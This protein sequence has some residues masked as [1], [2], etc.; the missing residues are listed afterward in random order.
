MNAARYGPLCPL[1]L[2]SGA[3]LERASAAL[4]TEAQ[5]AESWSEGFDKEANSCR[6]LRGCQQLLWGGR[7]APARCGAC[8]D[9]F[10]SPTELLGALWQAHCV[11][12]EFGP[13]QPCPESMPS[14]QQ[15][16][17]LVSSRE[18]GCRALSANLCLQA[19]P[20]TFPCCPTANSLAPPCRDRLGAAARVLLAA[21][22]PLPATEAEAGELA[23]AVRE[24]AEL[25]AARV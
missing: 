20:C 22:V 17:L 13:P 21:A 18:G 10:D 7:S 2:L 9:R 24:R 3:S 8:Q 4:R 11:M 16:T 14:H 23:R 15:N 19:L 5:R 1:Q 6:G 25:A 12:T